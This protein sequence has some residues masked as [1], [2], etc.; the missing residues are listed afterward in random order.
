M[1]YKQNTLS[2]H[3]SPEISHPDGGEPRVDAR[4]FLL[5]REGGTLPQHHHAQCVYSHLPQRLSAI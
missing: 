5:Q 2:T 3:R 4:S 1:G